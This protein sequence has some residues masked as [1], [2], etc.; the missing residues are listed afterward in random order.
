VNDT[1]QI[2][3]QVAYE[4]HALFAVELLD[5]VT[6]ERVSQGIAVTAVGL[7]GK[8]IVNHGGLFVWLREDLGPLQKVSVD[9]GALAY[10]PVERQKA[11]LNL[12]PAPRPLTTIELPPRVDYPFAAGL[13]AAR[14]TLIESRGGAGQ[15]PTPV[16]GALIRLRWLDEDGVTWH[17]APTWSKTSPHGDFAAFARLAPGDVP[18]LDANGALTARFRARREGTVDRE[19]ADFKLPQGR[20]ADPSTL[21][22][23]ILAWDELQP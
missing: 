2:Q 10:D 16:S 7:R 22:A 5:A 4:R 9:P 11:Q 13:T 1:K 3:L 14:G 17:D 12:P 6:L 15:P 18:H 8:P 21:S 20:V 23:L 19:S